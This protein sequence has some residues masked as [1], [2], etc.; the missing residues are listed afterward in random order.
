MLA[1]ILGIAKRGNKEVTNLGMFYRLQV[2]TRGIT[3]RGSL[4]DLKSRK[5][6][7]KSGQRF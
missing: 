7:Y 3:N 1:Y 4:K 2:R 6:D 5:K